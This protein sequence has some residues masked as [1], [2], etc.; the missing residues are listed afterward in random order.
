[1]IALY[2]ISILLAWWVTKRREA[3]EKPLEPSLELVPGD[4]A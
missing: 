2:N 1:M 3:K 4:A